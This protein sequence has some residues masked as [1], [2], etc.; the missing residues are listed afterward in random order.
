MNFS[1]KSNVI[2]I[3]RQ[4]HI[5]RLVLNRPE[6]R[7]AMSEAMWTVIPSAVALLDADPDVKVIIITSSDEGAFSAGADIS[8]LQTIAADPARRES[9]RLA[10]RDAQRCLARAKKPTIALVW[11]ACVGGGCGLAIHC[12]FR[13]AS[14]AAKFAITPAK[15][16]IVYPLNDTK[17]L[18]DLVGPSKAKSLL[19]TGRMILADEALDMGLIDEV[20]DADSLLE[21]TLAFAEQISTVSQYSV[22]NMKRFVQRVLDGQVDDDQVTAEI[23]KAAQEGEDAAEGV[24]AFLEKRPSAFRWNGG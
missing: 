5:G 6:K 2:Y 14:S 18:I 24:Q 8:E 23:F 10:I 1:D 11:G 3:E 17:Q 21:N 15:L 19:F 12:D 4:G 7:N 9:N 22:Q 16:G 20:Y 13:F